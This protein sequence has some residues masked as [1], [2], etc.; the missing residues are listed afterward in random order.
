MGGSG[1]RIRGGG[2]IVLPSP[3]TP[4]GEAGKVGLSVHQVG[5]AD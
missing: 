5:R 3:L 4:Y 2:V 1:A